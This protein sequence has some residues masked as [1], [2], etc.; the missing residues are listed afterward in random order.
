MRQPDRQAAGRERIPRRHQPA[1][2]GVAPLPVQAL[3]GLQ[4]AL[5]G[6]HHVAGEAS[7]RAG[8]LAPDRDAGDRQAEFKPDQVVGLVH[9]AVAPARVGLQAVLRKALADVVGGRLEGGVD[10][11]AQIAKDRAAVALQRRHHLDRAVHRQDAAGRSRAQQ[12]RQVVDAASREGEARGRRR[13][14]A[15]IGDR[16]HLQ[17]RLGA[18]EEGVEH[19]PVE[20][21]AGD[22]FLGEAVMAPHRVGGRGVV[23][24]QVLGALAGADHAKPRRAGPVDDLG[25]ERG[26]VAIGEGIDD[27]GLRRPAGDERAGQRVG[28]D[29]DHH[30][31]ALV[32]AAGERV[33][34][35]GARMARRLDDH[36]DPVGGDQPFR[37]VGEEGRALAQ[38]LGDA[39]RAVALRGPVDPGERGPC[40]LRIEVGDADDVQPRRAR[41]LRQ[42][43][44]AELAGPDHPDP[45]R[46]P[47]RRPRGELVVQAHGVLPR[48]ARR[49]PL[50][51]SAL[52]CSLQRRRCAN[53][54]GSAP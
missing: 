23:D 19:L 30:D 20:V 33:A 40:P 12:G 28:L 46:I 26:L 52:T 6:R 48:P 7:G 27:P 32:P 18:V 37:V 22:L 21:A 5:G 47:G 45:H 8:G 24:R 3:A 41:R 29:V 43:H 50:A 15:G 35:A 1:V 53:R 13:Q 14:L 51:S 49:R 38:R 9:R 42:E 2:D 17:R 11:P 39:P 10:A 44:R 4:V 54:R 34:D 16:R 36:L 25:D 31:V